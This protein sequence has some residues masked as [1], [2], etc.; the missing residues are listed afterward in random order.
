MKRRPPRS[1]LFPSTTLFRSQ[2][3]QLEVRRFEVGLVRLDFGDLRPMVRQRAVGHDPPAIVVNQHE[4]AA[5]P[6]TAAMR[7]EEHTSEL[8]SQSNLV[9]RLLLVK[10][11]TALSQAALRISEILKTQARIHTNHDLISNGTV[12]A[13]RRLMLTDHT[14]T[15]PYCTLYCIYNSG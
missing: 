2:D 4:R 7:S 10:K 13:K 5:A 8:Q 1:T 14:R 6:D 12:C 11:T 3:R 9:C 15:C